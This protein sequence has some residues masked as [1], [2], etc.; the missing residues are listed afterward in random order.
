M[1]TTST[2]TARLFL[3]LWPD[4]ETLSRL[5]ARRDAIQWQK[6]ARVSPDEKLHL[7]LH[8][9][10]QVARQRLPELREALR[11]EGGDIELTLTWL[12]V[13]NDGVAVLRPQIVPEALSALQNRLAERLQSVR[14]PSQEETYKHHV[15]FARNAPDAADPQGAPVLWRSSGYVLAESLAGYH[16]IERYE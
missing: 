3:A 2:A 8:F 6:G 1:M 9:V 7:T 13:W 5:A 14:L 12:D 4:S 10:G 16:V 11:T 15:T